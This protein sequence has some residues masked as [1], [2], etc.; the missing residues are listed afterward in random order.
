MR[1]KTIPS[2]R[3]VDMMY[4]GQGEEND[5]TVLS[6]E[7]VLTRSDLPKFTP[8]GGRLGYLRNSGPSENEWTRHFERTVDQKKDKCRTL[9]QFSSTCSVYY[10]IIFVFERTTLVVVLL[11]RLPASSYSVSRYYD[12]YYYCCHFYQYS[13]STDRLLRVFDVYY[14]HHEPWK[15]SHQSSCVKSAT[16]CGSKVS[17]MPRRPLW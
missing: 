7:P 8:K 9:F 16:V 2:P 3:V 4:F 14:C 13:E 5:P 10:E 15:T 6:L 11:L 17:R 1:T 12:Y